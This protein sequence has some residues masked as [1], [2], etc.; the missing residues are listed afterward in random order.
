M[1]S[2]YANIYVRMCGV[3][4]TQHMHSH[5]NIHTCMYLHTFIHTHTHMYTHL[6]R[7]PDTHTHPPTCTHTNTHIPFP[8]VHCN[9]SWSINLR[10]N[11]CSDYA[12][13]TGDHLDLLWQSV[14]DVDVSS[15]PVI[16]Q[17]LGDNIGKEGDGKGWE[18]ES[19][20]NGKFWEA[21]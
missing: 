5:A 2:T 8:R 19:F 16:G 10:W 15:H 9:C 12:T 13:I 3:L 14:N 11:D 7:H 18:Y 17:T 21:K 1:Y 20:Q 4:S 6:P